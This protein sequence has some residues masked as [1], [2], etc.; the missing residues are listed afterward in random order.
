MLITP[1]GILGSSSL[2]VPKKSSL[3]RQ[4][5]SSMRHLLFTAAAIQTP[6]WRDILRAIKDAGEGQFGGSPFRSPIHDDATDIAVKG[7][8][9]YGVVAYLNVKSGAEYPPTVFGT[10]GAAAHGQGVALS[11]REGSRRRSAPR[12]RYG[13]KGR[14]DQA[15]RLARSCENVQWL[16]HGTRSEHGHVRHRNDG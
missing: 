8:K 14:P 1:P 16:G 9:E 4:S 3:Q 11:R 5:S 7:W 12:S 2:L 6:A 10:D 13:A 15:G